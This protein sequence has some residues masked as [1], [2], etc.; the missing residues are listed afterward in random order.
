MTKYSGRLHKMLVKDA[1]PV[2]YYFHLEG[3]DA[4]AA[5]STPINQYLGQTLSMRFTGKINCIA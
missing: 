4:E 5:K 2:E 1:A 3:P